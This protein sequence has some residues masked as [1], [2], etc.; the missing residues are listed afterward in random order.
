MKETV[1]PV[2]VSTVNNYYKLIFTQDPPCARCAR[3]G[4]SCTRDQVDLMRGCVPCATDNIQCSRN[5]PHTSTMPP[6]QDQRNIALG[7]YV[8]IFHL[9]VV[10][11]YSI[12]CVGSSVRQ[13]H[14]GKNRLQT[15][16][17]YW[18]RGLYQMYPHQVKMQLC[19]ETRPKT[20]CEC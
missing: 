14:Q 15:F 11:G 17:R 19:W 9:A 7:I 18:D 1:S 4:N 8:S 5:E 20:G 16:S 3:I 13:L 12:C 6:T 2:N 10:V